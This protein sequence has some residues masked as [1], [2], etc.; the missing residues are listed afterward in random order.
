MS[1]AQMVFPPFTDFTDVS[2]N[3]EYL[4]ASKI[5]FLAG[6]TDIG[7]KINLHIETLEQLCDVYKEY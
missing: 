5:S 4:T 2:F 7:K 3:M 1:K 6:N